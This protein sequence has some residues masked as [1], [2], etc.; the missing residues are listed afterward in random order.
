VILPA[1]DA[2]EE[3]TGVDGRSGFWGS[4]IRSRAS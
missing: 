3:E 2:L 4:E 1:R